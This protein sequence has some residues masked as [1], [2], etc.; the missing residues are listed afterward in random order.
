[1]KAIADCGLLFAIG[2]LGAPGATGTRRFVGGV[3]GGE[4][5]SAS[6]LADLRLGIG[7]C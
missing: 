1:M 5:G 7:V 4:P 6:L 2:R 3:R